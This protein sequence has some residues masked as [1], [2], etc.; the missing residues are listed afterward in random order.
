MVPPTTKLVLLDRDGVINADS[1]TGVLAFEEFKFLPR[2]IEAIV[3]LTQAGFTIAVCTN[4]AAIGRGKTTHEIVAQVH[5]FLREKVEEAGGKIDAIYY[6]PDHPDSPSTRRKPAPGML[7]EA[8]IDLGGAPARTPFVGDMVRDLQA[9]HAAGCPRILVRTGKGA[10]LE[11]D[12]IPEYLQPV[13]VCDDLYD[14]ADHI[15]A[16]YGSA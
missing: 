12:G 8:M 15:I 6:A 7:L 10:K 5:G 1:P 3:R 4:Q 16:H 11:R 2:A 13:L 14:A 9:G